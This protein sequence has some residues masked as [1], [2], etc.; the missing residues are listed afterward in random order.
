MHTDLNLL[1]AS[2]NPTIRDRRALASGETTVKTANLR[3]S[4]AA[5][6]VTYAAPEPNLILSTPNNPASG[7]ILRLKTHQN[8]QFYRR[9]SGANFDKLTNVSASNERK[10]MKSPH[11]PTQALSTFITR[12]FDAPRSRLTPAHPRASRNDRRA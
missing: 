2:P 12:T 11:Q 3:H 1:P 7:S 5:F 9:F 8:P 6:R 10:T 4:F